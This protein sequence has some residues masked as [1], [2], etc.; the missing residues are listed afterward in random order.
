MA[1]DTAIVLNINE[2]TPFPHGLPIYRTGLSGIQRI[3]IL[4]YQFDDIP[5]LLGSQPRHRIQL[6]KTAA[7]SSTKNGDA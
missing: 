1:I 7:V 4:W 6:E 5:I 3:N 2:N